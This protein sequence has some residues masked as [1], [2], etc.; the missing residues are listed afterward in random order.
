LAPLPTYISLIGSFP[1]NFSPNLSNK[2]TKAV[3]ARAFTV[4]YLPFYF[5]KCTK[6]GP[7]VFLKKADISYIEGDANG[8]KKP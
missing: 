2:I 7:K 6:K 1:E 5:R 3:P 8:G 4:I